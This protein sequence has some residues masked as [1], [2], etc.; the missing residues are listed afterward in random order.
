MRRAF[1]LMEIM[2][3]VVITGLMVALALPK[4]NMQGYRADAGMQGVRSMLLEA[5]RMSL[6]HQFDVYIMFDTA[7]NK[8]ILAEDSN[9]DGII[10]AGEH[11]RGQV[12][13]QNVVF[14]VPP[15]G[16][17]S[18]VHTPLV[19][20]KFHTVD[21]LPSVA[22]H[23]DGSASTTMDIYLATLGGGSDIV[24]RAIR[25]YQA[26]ARTDWYKFNGTSWVRAGQ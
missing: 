25:L 20:G 16:I 19:A 9:N 2:L 5:S 15:V 7:A 10:E 1:T 22:F 23:R 8:M 4:L 17:D 3:V 12:L 11:I 13:D 24:Y 21:G 14:K 6:Q 18:V 26:T